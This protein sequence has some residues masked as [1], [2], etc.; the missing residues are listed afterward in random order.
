VDRLEDLR[1]RYTDQPFAH[2]FWGGHVGSIQLDE[3]RGQFHYL[4][5]HEGP[6]E[7]ITMIQRLQKVDQWG[8]LDL[9]NEDDAFG[10]LRFNID[11]KWVSRDLLDSIDELVLLERHGWQRTDPKRVLD[12]GAGYGRVAHRLTTAMPRANV[13]SVDAVA[14]STWL[15]EGYLGYRGVRRNTVVPFDKLYML[16]NVRFDI[17]VNIHAWTECT[18]EAV[19]FWIDRIDELGIP[20]VLFSG[21]ER[22]ATDSTDIVALLEDVGFRVDEKTVLGMHRSHCFVLKR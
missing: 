9:F 5:Q 12:I 6:D 1:Q 16:D 8:L 18:G 10:V 22:H 4:G 7:Y 2:S 13:W 11:G 19:K 20:T 17:A 15:C 3:F 21:N 14:E